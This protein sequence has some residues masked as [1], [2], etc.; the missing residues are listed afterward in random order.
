MIEAMGFMN[1]NI[2]A[3]NIA[4]RKP[5]MTIEVEKTQ[6]GFSSSLLAKMADADLLMILTA[7]D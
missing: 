5:M 3:R 7:V 1:K 4:V 2:A 6:C